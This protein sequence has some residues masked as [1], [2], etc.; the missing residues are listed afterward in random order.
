MLDHVRNYCGS[1]HSFW[2]NMTWLSAI[3]AFL[4]TSLEWFHQTCTAKR[5]TTG[6]GNRIIKNIETEWTFELATHGYFFCFNY[7]NPIYDFFLFNA[8]FDV[9]FILIG[10]KLKLLNAFF[11]KI[12]FFHNFHFIFYILFSLLCL[13]L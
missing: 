8:S 9:Y 11:L 3:G 6:D 13:I 1:T 10:Q 7:L 4:F 5:V 2:I 12:L